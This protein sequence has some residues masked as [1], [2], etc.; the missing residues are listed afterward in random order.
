MTPPLAKPYIRPTAADCAA[1]KLDA[2]GSANDFVAGGDQL[3]IDA[4]ERVGRHREADTLRASGLGVDGGV[5]ADD[6]AGHVDQ[7][8]AGVAGVDGRVGLDEALELAGSTLP[9]PGSSMER[10]FA[11][12]MPAETVWERPN[13][14][15]MARTQSPTCAPSE[16]P[17]LM[18]GSVWPLGS[19]LI[20]AMSVAGSMP[21]T[22]CG[23]SLIRGIDGVT[24]ELHIDVVGLIHDVIVGDDVAARIDDEAGP[25]RLALAHLR[26]LAAVARH[27]RRSG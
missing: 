20:T 22:C 21:T 12:T 7:R 10:S 17:I 2:D 4:D 15:P 18:V 13:G 6:L 25:Q 11:E 9:A 23:T 14:L 3:V 19:I 5:H 26:H 8:A 1:W 24:G 16:L 27:R